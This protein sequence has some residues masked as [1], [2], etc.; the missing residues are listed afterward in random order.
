[1]NVENGPLPA[2]WDRGLRA[3]PG[4]SLILRWR[5]GGLLLA[6]GQR[7]GL[8]LALGLLLLPAACAVPRWPIDGRLSSDYGLRFRGMSPDWHHGVD[9]AVPVGTPVHAMT[10]GT[11]T[12][13]GV[14]GGYGNVVMLRHSGGTRTVYGHLSRIDVSRGDAVRGRQVIGLS[15]RSG[16]ATGPHLHFEIVRHGRSDDPIRLLGGPPAR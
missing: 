16:N 2:T 15:G 1:M 13:A 10:H 4:A 3:R 8:L 5:R 7:G 12:F 14:L 11:V 9:I 6:P